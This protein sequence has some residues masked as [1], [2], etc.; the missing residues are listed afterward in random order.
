MYLEYSKKLNYFL[1]Y[2]CMKIKNNNQ[3]DNGF[4]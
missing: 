2:N 4:S 3:N 1:L